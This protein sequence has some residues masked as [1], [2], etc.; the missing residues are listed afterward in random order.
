[1]DFKVSDML[2]FKDN[3]GDIYRDCV[4]KVDKRYSNVNI[5]KVKKYLFILFQ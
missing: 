3:N 5:K 2:V 4:N 1:M